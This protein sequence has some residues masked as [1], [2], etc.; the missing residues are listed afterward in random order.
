MVVRTITKLCG[1]VLSL[2]LA[3]TVFSL[4]QPDY[5]Y[6]NS[7]ST[8]NATITANITTTTST[9]TAKPDRLKEVYEA[10]SQ[11]IGRLLA[12]ELYPVVSELIYDPELSTG[13]IGSLMKI[14]PALGRF[15]IW[16][17][18]MVDAMGRPH[19][20]TMQGRIAAYGAY[21]QC[22]AVRHNEG[23]F[24]G[25]YCML[26]LEHDGS[27]FSPSLRVIVNKFVE[28]YGFQSFKKL[29]DM[30]NWGDYSNDLGFVHGMRVFSATWVVLGHS[31]M[32]RDVHAS[33]KVA[34][35]ARLIENIETNNLFSQNMIVFM[36]G[37][38]TQ[39]AMKL[40][41][42][43]ILDISTRNTRAILN[44]DQEKAFDNIRH[45]FVLDDISKFNLSVPTGFLSGY[46]VMKSPRL[47]MS[48]VIVVVV[49]L[50]R[51]YIRLIIPMA[52]V[53]GFI[54][55]IPAMIDGPMM[56]EH[57]RSFEDTC[58]R[59]WWML[60]TMSQNYVKH[61]GDL[62]VP[63]F[64]YVAVDYQ[65]AIISTIILA[66]VMPKWPKVSMWIMGAIVVASSLGTLIQTYVMDALPFS[67]IVT[68]DMKR[69][70]DVQTEIYLKP[71]AHAATLFVGV[72]FGILAVQ[73]H[74]LSRLVQG[75][76]WAV[77]TGL[78]LAV[79]FGV[80]TWSVGRQPERLE[81]AF[82][83]GLHRVSW[84]LAIAWV[85]YAC[86]TGRGGFVT[87]ILAWPIMYPLGRL[88]FALYLVH[89]V[90]MG[91]T[92]VLGRELV[93]QQPFLHAQTYLGTVLMSYGFAIVLYLFVECPVAG[94]DN[95]AFEKVM[96][97][98]GNKGASKTK[99]IAQEL[100]AVNA[101]QANGTSTNTGF[102]PSTITNGFPDVTKLCSNGANLYG[103]VNSAWENDTRDRDTE[104]DVAVVSVKF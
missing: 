26:H 24:R 88:T 49:A 84:A 61:F 70:G 72:I 27:Q 17:I 71:Y 68:T 9:T 21:D 82:Y 63:H 77:A 4:A 13:C 3:S 33:W 73:R 52:A 75:V 32:V 79:L 64:W 62:C 76:A 104:A 1:V 99:S 103:H 6:A 93:S 30:P 96:P 25:R 22:L 29:L 7:A 59:T 85:M 65:L 86:A 55:L 67:L 78:A 5:R 95:T 45:E 38:S 37:I 15:D 42:I 16:A 56:R 44:I 47:K 12:R 74:R 60:F 100:K 2:L 92:T 51:R 8:I 89:L 97:K 98:H 57:R 40:I 28:H 50:F 19:A 58:D 48:P 43:Q 14:G 36:P 81:S 20:G 11:K 101:V 80:H 66:A 54:Y 23:L 39:D 91:S 69:I 34:K 35:Q 83:G 94:L 41:K 102:S 18:Q 10:F 31:H 53:L 87:K 90:V 46:L